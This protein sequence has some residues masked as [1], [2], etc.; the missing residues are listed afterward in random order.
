MKAFEFK[1][2]RGLDP[3][4]CR[5]KSL[6]LFTKIRVAVRSPAVTLIGAVE[7]P[8]RIE[9]AVQRPNAPDCTQLPVSARAPLASK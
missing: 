4:N 3:L 9:P 2:I 1:R 7:L 6:S 5:E 8:T